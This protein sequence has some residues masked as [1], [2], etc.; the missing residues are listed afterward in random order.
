M[1]ILLT[2]HKLQPGMNKNDIRKNYEIYKK[3]AIEAGLK[4]LGAVASLKKGFAHYQTEAE[5]AE[6]VR[7]AH[8]KVQVPIEDIVK[9]IFLP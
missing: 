1:T 6:Q 9:V 4:P 7:Q 5:T 3:S 2:I 8:S